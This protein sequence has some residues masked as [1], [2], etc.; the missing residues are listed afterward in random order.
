M[1]WFNFEMIRAA[2]N[3][4]TSNE[5]CELE[6]QENKEAFET[7]CNKDGLPLELSSCINIK[8]E[9]PS[10]EIKS[11]LRQFRLYKRTRLMTVGFPE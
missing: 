9:N 2:R 4:D 5:L 3:K 7:Y 8:F 6:S 10:E 11:F 1:I